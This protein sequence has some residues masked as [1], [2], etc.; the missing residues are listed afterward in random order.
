VDTRPID[1]DYM[2]YYGGD[3]EVKLRGGG[4]L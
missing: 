2:D 4:R 1:A 3:A